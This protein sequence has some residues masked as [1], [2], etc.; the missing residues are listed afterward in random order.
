M[1]LQLAVDPQPCVLAMDGF[2]I[3]GA[4]LFGGMDKRGLFG[5]KRL[6]AAVVW[7]VGKEGCIEKHRAGQSEHDKQTQRMSRLR[8]R[9]TWVICGHPG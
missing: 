6:A 3:G 4:D 9:N 2:D 5:S 8:L 7:F 1:P